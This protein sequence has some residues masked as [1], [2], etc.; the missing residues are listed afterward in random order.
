M[1]I[2]NNAE[3]KNG[4][5]AKVS[6][7]ACFRSPCEVMQLPRLGAFY[8]SFLSFSRSLVRTMIAQ[9]WR[10][11]LELDELDA[12]GFGR[13]V[14]LL[15]VPQDDGSENEYRLIFFSNHLEDELRSDRV[16]AESWD[17]C[18]CLWDGEI[19]ERQL[20]ELQQNLPR[21]ELGRYSRRILAISRANKSVR[22]F[23]HVVSSLTAGFQ[24][25]A[26]ALQQ[27]PYLARTTAVYGNGKFGF[28]DYDA[29][30]AGD[31]RQHFR[32]QMLL[33][34]MVRE[35]TFDLVEHIARARGG[36]R[37]ARLEP[38][39]KRYLGVGNSTGLGMA[40][41]LINHPATLHSWIERREQAL[42]EVMHQ[43]SVS[44]A[45]LEACNT[46]IDKALA[47]FAA[48]DVPDALQTEKNQRLRMDLLKLQEHIAAASDWLSI[49]RWL[50]SR[51][52]LDTQELY[53]N[54]VLECYP[55]IAAQYDNFAGRAQ[56]EISLQGWSVGA[57]AELIAEHYQWALTIDF[58]TDD[59]KNYFW[60]RSSHKQ[61][62]RLGERA[63]EA[64]VELQMQINIAERVQALYSS[65]RAAEPE[66]ALAEFLL[67]HCQYCA[68]VQRVLAYPQQPYGEIRANIVGS[69][70][71]PID[72]LRLKLSMFG[73]A[74]Y[75]PK[76]ARWLRITL[77][78]SAPTVAPD[79]ELNQLDDWLL[80]DVHI[81]ERT[82]EHQ[83]QSA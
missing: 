64:G 54:I 4:L 29:L 68:D 39:V 75:D 80:P 37:A 25:D 16:I 61:E 45:K 62:P 43:S 70:C 67:D 53:L 32:A 47:Y 2:G 31:F 27:T 28:A 46:Y 18:C 1:S 17:F 55:E 49:F 35:F 23:D 59:N 22:L 51:A 52:S 78:Q 15:H 30:A 66:Q 76:S 72:L 58:T 13:R 10:F 40:P 48:L 57:C 19:S 71:H 82:A 24:P 12:D 33:V 5:F 81:L 41:Y 38:E 79:G 74:R 65:L 83:Q 36:A 34:F 69:D 21:Q 11:T 20:V 9:R 26:S 6:N 77:F 8:P 73:A 42:Y 3:G 44:A 50:Q 63:A 60:Y 7:K 56:P 14:Y